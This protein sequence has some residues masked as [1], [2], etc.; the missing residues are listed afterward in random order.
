MAADRI[1]LIADLR[2]ATAR[3]EL[4]VYY[5]PVFS[6]DGENLVGAEALVHW[7]HPQLGLIL[8]DEFIP[9]AESAGLIGDI[10]TWVLQEACHQAFIW[11]LS[12]IHI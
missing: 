8:P 1:N 5:Q 4:R 11:A 9:A 3:G 12:L 10:G 6:L 7:Q 2:Q